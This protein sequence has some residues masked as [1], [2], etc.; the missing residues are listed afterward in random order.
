MLLCTCGVDAVVWYL[1]S[2]CSC[3]LVVLVQQCS[4]EGIIYICSC[5]LD[6]LPWSFVARWHAPRLV[7]AGTI[8]IYCWYGIMVRFDI[9]Y[10]KNVGMVWWYGLI[11][12]MEKARYVIWYVDGKKCWYG[13]MVRFGVLYIWKILR[14][15]IWCVG[16]AWWMYYMAK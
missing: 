13:I 11:Y 3:V 14:Y 8:L 12:Y 9:L 5:A 6:A 15:A 4:P 16:T 7:Y 1:Y 10:G 2:V